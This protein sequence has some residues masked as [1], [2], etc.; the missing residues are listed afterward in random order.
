MSKRKT[1]KKNTLCSECEKSLRVQQE[2]CENALNPSPNL[3]IPNGVGVR[4]HS[5]LFS[6]YDAWNEDNIVQSFR[7]MS[8]SIG[9]ILEAAWTGQLKELEEVLADE[10]TLSSLKDGLIRD[11]TG[12]TP[13]HL[14]AAC[15][16]VPC[17]QLL[18]QKGNNM[19]IP[20]VN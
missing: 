5:V 16:N 13:L 12:R 2:G 6:S 10:E 3:L 8:S 20:Q 11:K 1:I 14:S 18:I 9:N 17:V 4:K 15:G 19:L 7:E